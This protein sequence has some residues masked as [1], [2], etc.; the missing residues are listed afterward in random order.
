MVGATA[1]FALKEV[2]QLKEGES[3]LITGAAG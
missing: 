3:V 2:A 1:Y